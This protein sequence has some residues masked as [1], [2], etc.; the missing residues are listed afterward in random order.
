MLRRRNELSLGPLLPHLHSLM[1]PQFLFFQ[2]DDGRQKKKNPFRM[3]YTGKEA[4]Q[5]GHNSEKREGDSPKGGK[6][7][8]SKFEIL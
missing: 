4:M 8:K 7:G 1:A 2:A 6:I 3:V 5:Y